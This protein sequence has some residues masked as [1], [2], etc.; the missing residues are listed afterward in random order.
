MADFPFGG[1]PALQLQAATP[2]AGVALVNGTPTILIW[3]APADGKQHRFM[4]FASM[5]VTVTEVGGAVGVAFTTPD[6]G[7]LTNNAFPGLFTG[8]QGAGNNYA[9]A[10]AVSQVVKPGSTVVVAQTSALTS[11]AAVLWAEIW[12]S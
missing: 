7:S 5:N 4:V 2:V 11:G 8:A 6:Q 10:Y 1:V 3:T 12:G 9:Q